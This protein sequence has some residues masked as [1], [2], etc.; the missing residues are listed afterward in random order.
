[1]ICGGLKLKTYATFNLHMYPYRFG[2]SIWEDQG[3]ARKPVQK[4]NMM[5]EILVL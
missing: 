3:F 2:I 5:R 1:M 4:D